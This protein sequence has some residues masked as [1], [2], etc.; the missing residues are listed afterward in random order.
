M[1]D[2]I[3]EAEIGGGER[4]GVPI[5]RGDEAAIDKP[6]IEFKLREI[7]IG[8]CAEG[9]GKGRKALLRGVGLAVFEVKL[10]FCEQIEAVV[11]VM[12]RRFRRQ[13]GSIE[14]TL[15]GIRKTAG[16]VIRAELVTAAESGIVRAGVHAIREFQII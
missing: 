11:A 2:V 10:L 1:G 3:A 5:A 7:A 12:A 16:V 4:E 14:D 15:I 6:A 8:R 13:A 9:A